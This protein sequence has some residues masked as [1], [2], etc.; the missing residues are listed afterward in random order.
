MC[1]TT[2]LSCF[3]RCLVVL[4]WLAVG[5]PWTIHA[6]VPQAFSLWARFADEAKVLG[7]AGE[8]K[9]AQLAWAFGAVGFISL[10]GAVWVRSMRQRVQKEIQ[11]SHQRE[12]E[13]EAALRRSEEHVGKLLEDREKLARDL[14][15]G[16]IQSI[17][18]AGLNIEECRRLIKDQPTMVE[19][20]LGRVLSDLNVLMREVRGFIS[21]LDSTARTSQDFRTAIK[22]LL[23]TF[24]DNHALRF[25]CNID[26]IASENLTGKQA[27][28][29]LLIA[30]EAISNSIRHAAAERIIISLKLDN[31]TLRFEVTDNGVGFEPGGA[32]FKGHGFSN[33]TARAAE[34]RGKFNC[35]SKPGGGT[36]IVLDIPL[37]NL[38]QSL[39]HETDSVAH[40][41]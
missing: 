29:L 15:D 23:L 35:E 26:P 4:I 1:R 24:G 41:R 9:M 19:N 3:G 28:D 5:T 34:L 10:F 30:R 27:T 2:A 8:W 37:E 39:A 12:E 33:I 14:H 7:L 38:H 40:R 25:N 13:A 16:V 20:R 6:Q 11:T 32:G 36:R 22:S 17:Y 31:Q 18:A 21:G